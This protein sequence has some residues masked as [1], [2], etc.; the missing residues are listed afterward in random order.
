MRCP[1]CGRDSFSL[2]FVGICG[3][4]QIDRESA[5]WE[6]READSLD[7]RSVLANRCW[8]MGKWAAD[9]PEPDWLG[10]D[11]VIPDLKEK[12]NRR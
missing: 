9:L 2:A 11:F 1:D 6:R 7:P 12:D 10:W 8:E 3:F 5:D 4:C